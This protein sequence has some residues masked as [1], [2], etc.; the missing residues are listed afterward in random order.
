MALV[1]FTVSMLLAGT[2][3]ALAVE[4]RKLRDSLRVRDVLLGWSKRKPS[5]GREGK[6]R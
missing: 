2:T 1:W 4:V 5:M 3:C 6:R